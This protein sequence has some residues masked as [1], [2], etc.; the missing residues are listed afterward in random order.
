MFREVHVRFNRIAHPVTALFH[1]IKHH[2]W[3]KGI[4]ITDE[5]LRKKAL[6]L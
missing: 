4:R 6:M 1:L 5:H 2:I 3:Y